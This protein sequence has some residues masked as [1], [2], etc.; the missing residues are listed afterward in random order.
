MPPIQAQLFIADSIFLLCL[1]AHI[2]AQSDSRSS[3][4]QRLTIIP[5]GGTFAG[6]RSFHKGMLKTSRPPSSIV[7]AVAISDHAY[8]ICGRLRRPHR[9]FSARSCWRCL[10][11]ALA[12]VSSISI[13]MFSVSG[14]AGSSGGWLCRVEPNVRNH[15]SLPQRPHKPDLQWADGTC[16]YV[17]APQAADSAF[18]SG[19]M[20]CTERHLISPEAQFSWEIAHLGVWV[21]LDVVHPLEGLQGLLGLLCLAP[22][23]LR[24]L[25]LV[26]LLLGL[27]GTA[28]LAQSAQIMQYNVVLGPFDPRSCS[29]YIPLPLREGCLLETI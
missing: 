7:V 12:T 22:G 6:Q 4:P 13:S 20:R 28:G 23:A 27:H 15:V 18:L 10:A 21:C 16:Q 19:R 17:R 25:R 29:E 2:L 14:L 26:L 8:R 5:M 1:S 24:R 3:H 9:I 11:A